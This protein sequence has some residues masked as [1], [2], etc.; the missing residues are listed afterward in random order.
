LGEG[1]RGG[2][3]RERGGGKEGG[4]RCCAS[5]LHFVGPLPAHK[6]CD[7]TPDWHR[8]LFLWASFLRSQACGT[9]ASPARR[10]A[11]LVFP[12][13]RIHEGGWRNERPVRREVARLMIDCLCADAPATLP[14]PPPHENQVRNQLRGAR[15]LRWQLLSPAP[16]PPRRARGMFGRRSVLLQRRVRP[17]YPWAR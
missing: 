10:D 4:K 15:G 6:I 1:W 11:L 13:G 17:D 9:A 8:S 2:R 12:R 7:A 14:P 5:L 3:G 16:P